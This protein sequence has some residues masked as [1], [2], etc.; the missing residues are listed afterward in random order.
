MYKNSLHQ[1][2]GINENMFE[3]MNAVAIDE[4]VTKKGRYGTLA[5]DEMKIQVI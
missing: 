3:W 4:N 2:P 1:E 5:L